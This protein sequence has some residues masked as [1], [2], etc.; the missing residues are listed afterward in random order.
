MASVASQILQRVEVGDSQAVSDLFPQV[1]AELRRLAAARMAQERCDHTLQATGL[2]HEA[3]VRLVGAESESKFNSM[4]HFFAAAAEAMRRILIDHARKKNSLKRGA[5]FTRVDLTNCNAAEPL[6]VSLDDLLDLD[7]LLAQLQS[8]DPVVAQIVSLRLY[9]GLSVAEA[10]QAVGVSR[11]TGY[12]L[13]EY[14]LSWFAAELK[15][16]DSREPLS[17]L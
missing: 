2:V 17:A 10:S 15:S 1:Y 7:E 6:S 14:A 8:E 16:I 4:P 12:Q 5:E 9:T 3:F 11:S 13:W